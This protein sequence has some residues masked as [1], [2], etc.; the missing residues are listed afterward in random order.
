MLF[1]HVFQQIMW[2]CCDDTY[3]N[4]DCVDVVG[5]FLRRGH[6]EKSVLII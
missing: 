5:A 2:V 1:A 6:E 4:I 3:M